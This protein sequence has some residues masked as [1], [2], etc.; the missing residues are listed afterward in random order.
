MNSSK[1]SIFKSV[2]KGQ[3]IFLTEKQFCMASQSL[4]FKN[5]NMKTNIFTF[6][7][8]FTRVPLI[9]IQK[10]GIH[11]NHMN[12]EIQKH[13]TA[14]VRL[15]NN[16]LFF[17]RGIPEYDNSKRKTLSQIFDN[18]HYQLKIRHRKKKNKAINQFHLHHTNTPSSII[19]I[20][21]TPN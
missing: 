14:P 8:F 18:F 1:N 20:R 19:K 21:C 10:S 5:R 9:S 17:L 6:I 15:I 16:L 7:F 2:K 11:S 3:H 4:S 12:I 13:N